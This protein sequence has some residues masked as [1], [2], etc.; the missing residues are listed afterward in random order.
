MATECEL[1][2]LVRMEHRGLGPDRVGGF[3]GPGLAS[4]LSRAISILFPH[5]SDGGDNRKLT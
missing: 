3:T 4:S 2:S 1:S 5:S